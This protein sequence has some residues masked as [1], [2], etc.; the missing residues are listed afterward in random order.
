MVEAG[1]A[2]G[3]EEVAES[4]AAEME[5]LAAKEGLAAGMAAAASGEAEAAE[6]EGGLKEAAARAAVA[7]AAEAKAAAAQGEVGVEARAEE[8]G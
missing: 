5:G 1:W 3:A 8:G 7:K 2:E 4:A 6:A